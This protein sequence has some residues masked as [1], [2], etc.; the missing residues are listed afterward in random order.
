V[1]RVLRRGVASGQDQAEEGRAES[2]GVS[3]RGHDGDCATARGGKSPQGLQ[4]EHKYSIP[5]RSGQDM[6]PVRGATERLRRV[7]SSLCRRGSCSTRRTGRR[8]SK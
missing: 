1:R 4:P 2:R 5:S 8:R 3:N 7:E 6:R